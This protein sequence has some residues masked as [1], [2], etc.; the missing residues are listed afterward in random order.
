MPELKYDIRYTSRIKKDLKSLL[1]RGKDMRKFENVVNLLASGKKLPP[2]YRDHKLIGAK[3]GL[4]DCHIEPNWLLLYKIE[5]DTLILEL[6]RT[7]SH[8]D[9]F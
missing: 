3:N 2:K 4:R 7:G 8:A 1:K 6:S 5:D 9:L